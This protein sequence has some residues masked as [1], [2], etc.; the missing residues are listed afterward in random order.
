MPHLHN[1]GETKT[2]KVTIIQEFSTLVQIIQTTE[3]SI[4]HCSS[5][6]L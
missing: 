6:K 3:I 1:R 4:D 5:D 2:S